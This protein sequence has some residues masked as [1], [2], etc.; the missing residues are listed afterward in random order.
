MTGSV[1]FRMLRWWWKP[2]SGQSV[3]LVIELADW[4]TVEDM[5]QSENYLRELRKLCEFNHAKRSPLS[6]DESP[7][8]RSGEDWGDPGGD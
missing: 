3:M 7:L 6:A 5:R 2:E 8:M 4:M 1:L